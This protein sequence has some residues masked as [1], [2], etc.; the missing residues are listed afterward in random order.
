MKLGNFFES[1]TKSVSIIQIDF[2][3]AL[4]KHCKVIIQ[5]ITP[6][7]MSTTVSEFFENIVTATT[8]E[9]KDKIK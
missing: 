5:T 3:I 7:V 9:T 6:A 4:G 2:D 1:A 8:Q